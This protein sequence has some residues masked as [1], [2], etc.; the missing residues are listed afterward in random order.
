MTTPATRIPS[1]EEA[2]R[3]QAA[4][5]GRHASLLEAFV[6]EHPASGLGR[7]LS[8]WAR[9]DSFDEAGLKSRMV[10][11]F[12]LA[13]AE[14]PRETSLVYGIFLCALR[15]DRL[16]AEHLLRHFADFPADETAALMLHAFGGVTDPDLRRAGAELVERQARLA[17][18]E[19]W[20][21]AQ[22]TAWTR[23]EQG[24]T[25]EG[26]EAAER[27][28]SLFSR[29]GRAVHALAHADH[30]RGAGPQAVAR[31]DGWLLRNPGA[32]QRP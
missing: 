1:L 23:V 6:A 18:P 7:A 26:V 12:E 8:V 5:S 32:S 15:Q 22:W 30:E 24:R 4:L 3:E 20:L 29:A 2:V 11:A 14:G 17:G 28:L 13:K 9:A 25:D 16:A 31:T 27:A 21:W 19:S 10:T